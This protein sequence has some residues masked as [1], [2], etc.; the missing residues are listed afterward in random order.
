MCYKTY[1]AVKERRGPNDNKVQVTPNALKVVWEEFYISPGL[2]QSTIL[3]ARL[4]LR[5]IKKGKTAALFNPTKGS[6]EKLG[7]WGRYVLWQILHTRVTAVALAVKYIL[8]VLAACG[9]TTCRL[10]GL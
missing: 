7:L 8:E 10:Y 5:V 3:G 2:L 6:A 4:W 1:G 9:D